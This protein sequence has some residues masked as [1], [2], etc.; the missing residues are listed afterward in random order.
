V[1]TILTKVTADLAPALRPH[2]VGLKRN[3]LGVQ[4]ARAVAG[5]LEALMMVSVE[6]P[7][8]WESPVIPTLQMDGLGNSMW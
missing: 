2:A 7:G 8:W 4:L 3:G 1:K 5:Q 6:A